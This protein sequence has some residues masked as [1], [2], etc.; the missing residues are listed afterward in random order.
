MLKGSDDGDY[1]RRFEKMI[2]NQGIKWQGK[3]ERDAAVTHAEYNGTTY[4]VDH[5]S[6][7]RL[8]GKD[9]IIP[10]MAEQY[11][12][13][14][15]ITFTNEVDTA[16][17]IFYY[18]KKVFLET[19]DSQKVGEMVHAYYVID[20]PEG[21]TDNTGGLRGE[22]KRL[23]QADANLSDPAY[24]IYYP[25]MDRS[26]IYDGGQLFPCD[27]TQR[28]IS[29]NA[30][31][32][33]VTSQLMEDQNTANV[34][35]EDPVKKTTTVENHEASVSPSDAVNA[36]DSNDKKEAEKEVA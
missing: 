24:N 5:Y 34:P 36:I 27:A 1:T 21:T 11:H 13:A 18:T 3:V 29:D 8:S 26:M 14:R 23:M 22:L 10:K 16:K 31:A 15:V 32:A 4:Y 7:M 12:N 25:T 30:K 19:R 9:E 35:N 33:A 2:A 28:R 6:Y 17:E 20:L